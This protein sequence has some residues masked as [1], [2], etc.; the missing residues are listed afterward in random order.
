MGFS[1]FKCEKE[2]GGGISELRYHLKHSH[3]LYGNHHN[4]QCFQDGCMRSYSGYNS[5]R[6]HLE[7][8]TVVVQILTK[9]MST[10]MNFK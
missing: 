3:G 7:M 8:Y 1:C 10:Q 2:I 6:K 5:Y 4:F 9:Q